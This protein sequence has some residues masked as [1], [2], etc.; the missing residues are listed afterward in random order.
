MVG[1]YSHY[2][3]PRPPHPTRRRRTHPIL[4]TGLGN[5]N[6]PVT[7]HEN[8]SGNLIVHGAKLDNL[9]GRIGNLL[10]AVEFQLVVVLFCQECKLICS[11]PCVSGS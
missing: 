6:A 5:N 8:R 11:C 9:L 7:L 4:A 3:N 1:R 10:V 2:T